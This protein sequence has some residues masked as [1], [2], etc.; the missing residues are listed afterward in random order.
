MIMYN[1]AFFALL[2]LRIVPQLVM[3]PVQVIT[4]FILTKALSP[5]TKKYLFEK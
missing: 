2:S 5:I 3:V 4:L 1:K